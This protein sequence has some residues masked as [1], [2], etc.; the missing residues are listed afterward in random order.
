MVDFYTYYRVLHFTL[1]GAVNNTAS[2]VIVI[3]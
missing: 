3:P 1:K 2:H